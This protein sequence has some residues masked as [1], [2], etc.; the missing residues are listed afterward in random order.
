MSIS[1]AVALESPAGYNRGLTAELFL[2]KHIIIT[3]VRD[4]Q[5]HFHIITPQRGLHLYA[6]LKPLQLSTKYVL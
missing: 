2:T 5:I 6:F 4:K 3:S 1:T